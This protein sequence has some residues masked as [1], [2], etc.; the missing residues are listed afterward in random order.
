MVVS[1]YRSLAELPAA[2]RAL[3]DGDRQRESQQGGLWFRLLLQEAMS[4]GQ[5]T[6]IWVVADD[7]G[8][9]LVLLPLRERSG[10]GRSLRPQGPQSLNAPFASHCHPF[11]AEGPGD[12]TAA[13]GALFRAVVTDRRC[14]S[15]KL[16]PLAGEGPVYA[17]MIEGMRVAGLVVH[18]QFA[19]ANWYLNV[20]GRSAEQYFE[21]IPARL[22]NTIR[23][24]TGR[25]TALERSGIRV[26]SGLEG[27]EDAI[28]DCETVYRRGWQAEQT[29]Q[30]FEPG[31]WR[32]CAARG[33]LR[34]GLLYAQGEPAAAQC[35][36][37]NG[38]T[39]LIFSLAFDGQFGQLSP[40]T[41]LMAHMMRH[42]ID[43]DRV[44]RVD[45][46]VGDDDYKRDWMSHRR[47][48]WSLLGLN[49]RTARGRLGIVRHVGV[50][51]LKR[52]LGRPLAP[53]PRESSGRHRV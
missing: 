47:E 21:D 37:V 23:R 30:G 45:F 32:A 1:A 50:R 26:V 42:V 5:Q 15:I 53:P 41:V 9:P 46:L 6:F 11:V 12:L 7:Q 43:V 18:P 29:Y 51:T 49:P 36:L 31:L 19:F 3:I 38:E 20:G 52:A 22:S 25:F 16:G 40:G 44:T 4:L 27:L 33:W 10:S 34:L 2:A 13:F 28:A 17:A 35:W 14:D 8:R 39:A 24:K 48:R